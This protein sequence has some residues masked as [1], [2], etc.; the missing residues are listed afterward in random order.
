M[1]GVINLV[2][3][4]EGEASSAMVGGGSHHTTIADGRFV[5][6]L[7]RGFS[8]T[9]AGSTQNDRGQNLFYPQ[10]N[11]PENNN[12][13]SVGHDYDNYR[14]LMGTVAGHGLRFLALTASRTKGVPTGWFGSDF[15]RQQQFTDGRSLLSLT[16]EHRASS[17]SQLFLRTSYDRY[18]YHGQF[19]YSSEMGRDHSVSTRLNTDLRYVWDAAPNHRVTL[20]AEYVDNIRASYTTFLSGTKNTIGGPFSVGSVYAQSEFQPAHSLSVTTGLRYD[21]Y[22]HVTD[23]VNPRVAVVWHVDAA[24]T[25]K[26][27]YGS[28][29][30]LPTVFEL[31]LEDASQNFISNQ[32]LQPEKIRQYE[33]VWEGRLTP[34]VLISVSPYRLHMTGLI[35]QQTDPVTGMAQYQNLN[36]VTSQGVEV[37]VD[38]RRSNGLWSYASYSR[39]DAREDGT[40]MLNSAANLAKA[41]ISTPTSHLLQGALELVYE[42]GRKSLA[43][44]ETGAVTLAN[45]TLSAALRSSFRL[46]V[47]VKNLLNTRYATP[48]SPAQP[49]DAIP[50]N[51]RTFLIRLRVGG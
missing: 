11:T 2:L 16:A 43:G 48:G 44:S 40:G 37:Q 50:Q 51:G 9:I 46:S 30:R 6:D 24:N 10:F 5:H 27:L 31:G 32:N 42:S 21:R 25:L 13:V 15:N 22:A 23:T 7:S 47:T 38:Y 45:M 19:P 34:E 8:M 26:V 36:D 33:V 28:A 20:G 12:G 1:F 39:Q 18:D 49:E 14:N 35:K 17:T 3:K 29:F 41:G 4:S